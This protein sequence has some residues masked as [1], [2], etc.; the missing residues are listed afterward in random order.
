MTRRMTVAE[1]EKWEDELRRM[2]GGCGYW[3]TDR[4]GGDRHCRMGHQAVTLS[5]RHDGQR[6]C[7]YVNRGRQ[8]F[9]PSVASG[10]GLGCF[11]RPGDAR[12]ALMLAWRQ[13]ALTD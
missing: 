2:T 3:Y 11:R 1:S 9:V 5:Y 12:R 13:M 8:T 7:A 4:A 6:Y 10:R